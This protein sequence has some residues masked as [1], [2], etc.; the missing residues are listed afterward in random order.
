MPSPSKSK[1][2]PVVCIFPFSAVEKCGKP[3]RPDRVGRG[4]IC[5][6]D[7]RWYENYRDSLRYSPGEN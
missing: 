1:P 4:G 6:D 3:V 5:C 2:K 7:H